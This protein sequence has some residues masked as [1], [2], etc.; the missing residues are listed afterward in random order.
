MDIAKYF[1]RAEVVQLPEEEYF[2]VANVAVSEEIA[3]IRSLKRKRTAGGN[4]CYNDET[5]TK[6][7]RYAAENGNTS[8]VRKF[9]EDLGWPVPF[10]VC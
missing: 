2:K 9:S 3:K 1:K 5:K 10:F 6:I 8:G 7:A 4:R